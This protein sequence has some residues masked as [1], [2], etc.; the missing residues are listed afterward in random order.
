MMRL[1]FKD[2]DGIGVHL[3]FATGS[4]YLGASQLVFVVVS[5][6]RRNR[7]GFLCFS[8]FV[9]ENMGIFFIH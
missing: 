1:T 7:W 3:N 5:S 2:L 9:A 4:Q 6:P 8:E